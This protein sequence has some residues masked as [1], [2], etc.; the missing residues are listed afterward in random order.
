[1]RKALL[2]RLSQ[3]KKDDINVTLTKC[4]TEF[5]EVRNV[6]ESVEA[7]HILN[8]PR[9]GERIGCNFCHALLTANECNSTIQI[10]QSFAHRL[11]V[12]LG[13]HATSPSSIEHAHRNLR[14]DSVDVD[15]VGLLEY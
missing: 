6:A 1:M 11:Q 4:F 12:V 13:C 14:S 2:K 15:V 3:T 5:G 8:C 7:E 9:A 10:V